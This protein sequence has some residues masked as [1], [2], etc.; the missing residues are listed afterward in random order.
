MMRVSGA[1]FGVPAEVH[2]ASAAAAVP[3]LKSGGLLEAQT[4]H[5][6]LCSSVRDTNVKVVKVTLSV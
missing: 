5:S 4:N 2:S 6:S 3:P 1:E